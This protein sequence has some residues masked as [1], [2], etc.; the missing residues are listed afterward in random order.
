MQAQKPAR[1]PARQLAFAQGLALQKPGKLGLERER[2]LNRAISGFDVLRASH[3][4]R[5]VWKEPELFH[6]SMLP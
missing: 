3:D 4:A 1:D 2:G 6:G 5:H